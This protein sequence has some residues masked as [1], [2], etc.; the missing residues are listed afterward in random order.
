MAKLGHFCL[1]KLI[2]IGDRYVDTEGVRVKTKF[3]FLGFEFR[4]GV[5]RWGKPILKRRTSREKLQVSLAKFKV[6]FKKYSGIPKKILFMKLNRKLQG[7]YNYYGI[8]GNYKS[9]NSFFY[10]IW[11]LLYKWLNRRSQRKSYTVDGFK[12]LVK[13]FEIAKPRICHDF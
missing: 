7:Y 6:W 2:F 3:D 13:D 1:L 8:R 5:N 10:R 4:W 11:K 9:L 12:A